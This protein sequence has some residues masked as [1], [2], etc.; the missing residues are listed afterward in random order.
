MCRFL[1]KAQSRVGL[2]VWCCG[3]EWQNSGVE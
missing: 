3:A 1:L 2:R